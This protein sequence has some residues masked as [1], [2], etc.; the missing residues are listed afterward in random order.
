MD[1][2]LEFFASVV[3]WGSADP[4]VRRRRGWIFLGAFVATA[5]VIVYAVLAGD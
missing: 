2:L 3:H 5:A 1:A 4:V